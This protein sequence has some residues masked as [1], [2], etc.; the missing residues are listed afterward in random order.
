MTNIEKSNEAQSTAG[1]RPHLTNAVP[2]IFFIFHFH[3]SKELLFLA[4]NL[5]AVAT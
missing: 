2:R 4:Q 3:I 5:H 1:L